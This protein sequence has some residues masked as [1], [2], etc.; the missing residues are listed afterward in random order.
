MV[1]D[2]GSSGRF[3]EKIDKI[4]SFCSS[5]VVALYSLLIQFLLMMSN[6]K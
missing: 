3:D 1:V 5:I 2:C 4:M 6:L